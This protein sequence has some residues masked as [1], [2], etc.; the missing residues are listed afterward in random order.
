MTTTAPYT[1]H[2]YLDAIRRELEKRRSAYPKIA[3]K[4]EK[5][6]LREAEEQ[7]MTYAEAAQYVDSNMIAITTEQ[8]IQ[9]ELLQEAEN[10]LSLT[11][12]TPDIAEAIWRELLRELRMRK[13]CYLR[14]VAFRR[15]DADTAEREIH[16][17]Q[18]LTD[19]FH[20][21]YCPDARLRIRRARKNP[22][23][24]PEKSR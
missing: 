17:W 15:M 24:I 22:G 8:R 6:W 14:W 4:K 10:Y 18:A 12:P 9:Y 23:K 7:L 1:T 11:R 21:T 13:K 16:I 19:Y 3:A 5:Q 2:D 20:E